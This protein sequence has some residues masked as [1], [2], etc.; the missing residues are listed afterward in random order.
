[1]CPQNT[2]SDT[3]VHSFRKNF[4][5]LTL[6][7][8][9]T[10]NIWG[11]RQL[12]ATC[13]MDSVL[14]VVLAT[15]SNF[16]KHVLN[17]KHILKFNH[18]RNIRKELVRLQVKILTGNKDCSCKQLVKLLVSQGEARFQNRQAD[19]G[20]FLQ[21]LFTELNIDCVEMSHV[22]F[23]TDNLIDSAKKLLKEAVQK[24]GLQK[25][26]HTNCLWHVPSEVLALYKDG[27]KERR[28]SEFVRI[29][30]DSVLSEEQVKRRKIDQFVIHSADYLVYYFDRCYS[31]GGLCINKDIYDIDGKKII[32]K[33]T[34][35][36]KYTV[37]DGKVTFKV[38]VSGQTFSVPTIHTNPCTQE[39]LGTIPIVPEETIFLSLQ[40]KQTFQLKGVVMHRGNFGGGHYTSVFKKYN[41]D[42]AFYNDSG[43]HAG[44]GRRVRLLGDY[45]NI[46]E[47]KQT[48]GFDVKTDGIL[49]F[50][51]KA[52]EK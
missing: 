41:G 18:A 33:N 10:D 29:T 28:I 6:E 48:D 22:V 50:Y 4:K 25:N 13:Y 36:D 34:R 9:L 21:F 26:I 31:I 16:I 40:K 43:I 2:G 20:E 8:V 47:T 23:R 12:G 5:S 46:F 42:W 24:D 30:L 3:D 27:T 45:H 52:V 37:G 1:M 49:Y 44:G 32:S 17:Q 15:N 35:V 39:Y 7:N 51:D 38:D 11:P 14:M 19:A